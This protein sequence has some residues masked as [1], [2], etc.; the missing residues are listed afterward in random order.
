MVSCD[1][2]TD[3]PLSDMIAQFRL[4]RPAAIAMM[5]ELPR[6][7]TPIKDDGRTVSFILDCSFCF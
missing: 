4:H 5:A 2:L 1:L 7:E 6:V 3:A